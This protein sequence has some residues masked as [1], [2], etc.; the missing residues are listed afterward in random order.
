[1]NYD[2]VVFFRFGRNFMCFFNDALLLKRLFDNHVS[3]WG[4]RPVVTVY[5]NWF[6]FYVKELLEKYDKSCIVVDQV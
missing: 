1:M 4:K 5:D 6:R 3:M 2:K